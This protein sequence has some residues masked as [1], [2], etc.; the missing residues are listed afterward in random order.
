ML[1][2]QGIREPGGALSPRIPNP[3]SCLVIESPIV[4]EL[5][6]DRMMLRFVT[7]NLGNVLLKL[8]LRRGNMGF[9]AHISSRGS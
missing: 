5:S 1:D 4:E 2:I 3:A 7:H 9:L 6:M 8:K